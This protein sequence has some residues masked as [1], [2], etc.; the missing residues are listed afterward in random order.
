V[1]RSNWA[2]MAFDHNA[3]PCDGTLEG[4]RGRCSAEIAKD[5]IYI[6]SAGRHI[7]SVYSGDVSIEDPHIDAKRATPQGGVFTEKS[8]R[9]PPPLGVGFMTT[10]YYVSRPRGAWIETTMRFPES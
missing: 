7:A 3:D 4:L 6:R 1:A 2:L 8:A 10:G 5:F 9:K